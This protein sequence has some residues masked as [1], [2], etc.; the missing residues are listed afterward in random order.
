M[1]KYFIFILALAGLFSGCQS[2]RDK[3]D[4]TVSDATLNKI[5]P[6]GRA[7][8]VP[9]LHPAT[10]NAGML[11]GTDKIYFMGDRK[12]VRQ[13]TESRPVLVSESTHR[14]LVG[15]AEQGDISYQPALLDRELA[16][17]LA[18]S[19]EI[20]V[21]NRALM[22]QMISSSTELV[23]AMDQLKQFNAEL[24]RKLEQQIIY[25]KKLEQ[26]VVS[27]GVKKDASSEER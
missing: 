14:L 11:P 9:P 13:E 16:E 5:D 24:A 18:R 6:P 1:T 21:Q 3:S 27:S 12:V 7:V 22:V 10:N 20:N 17:E 4:V 19:R 8:S 25:S 26:K 23:N 2:T 15:N